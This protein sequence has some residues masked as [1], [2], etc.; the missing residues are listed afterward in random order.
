VI[1]TATNAGEGQ[2]IPVGKEPRGIAITPNGASA[3][4][5]NFQDDTVSVINTAT[6]TV[7]TT[8]ALGQ[9]QELK[10][11]Q[12]VAVAPDG[13]KV[14]VVNGFDNSVSVIDTN[15]N[16]VLTNI[17]VGTE[18]QEIA[19]TSD[20]TRAYVTS[21][22]TNSV[23]VLDLT[24]NTTVIT[25]A[26]G[27]TPDGVA[28]SP[29]GKV[30]VANYNFNEVVDGDSVSIIDTA[31]NTTVGN[32]VAVGLHPVKIAFSPDGTR[33][34]VTS[35]DSSTVEEIDTATTTILNQILTQDAPN[36]VVVGAKGK[37]LYIA[38]FGGNGNGQ[39]IEVL[40]PI[41]SGTIALIPVGKGPIAVALT[42]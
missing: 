17:A 14:Y 9:A 2:P 29:D 4:V 13:T 25:V 34:Y 36:G 8:I 6:N 23:T 40:S 35:S 41:S 20:G 32:P 12:G 15:T 22:A 27:Q 5:T 11:P 16:S 24:T 30:Y 42:P 21:F 39:Q 28:V 37:R 3:Y 38:L 1:N 7:S 10:G 33:A 31:T 18:P 26:V 19:L